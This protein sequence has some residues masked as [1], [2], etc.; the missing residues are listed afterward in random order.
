MFILQININFEKI[1][2]NININ[3]KTK[4]HS[5]SIDF[6]IFSFILRKFLQNFTVY[7]GEKI[8]SK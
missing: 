1:P 3:T 6:E 2:I 4:S 5:S 8:I 7:E